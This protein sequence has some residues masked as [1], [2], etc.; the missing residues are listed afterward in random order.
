MNNIY[1]YNIYDIGINNYIYR[2]VKKFLLF[3]MDLE[4][5]G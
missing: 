4:I 1:Q 2:K 5:G 3:V